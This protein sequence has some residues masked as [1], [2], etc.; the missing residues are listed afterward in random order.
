MT[1]PWATNYM[2]Y[3]E[4]TM[5]ATCPECEAQINLD[6]AVKGDIVVCQ[7][8]GVELEVRSKEPVRLEIAAKTEEDWGE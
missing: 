2:S 7:D 3:Q 8:C 4:I 6:D 1:S 5:T